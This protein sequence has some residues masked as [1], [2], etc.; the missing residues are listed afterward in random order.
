MA[1]LLSMVVRL[2]ALRTAW[3]MN[4]VSLTPLGMLPSLHESTKRWSKS[5]LRVSSTPMICV[6]TM[7]SPWKGMLLDEIIC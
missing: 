3:G 6:P 7:G 2:K 1:T 4:E 5:R